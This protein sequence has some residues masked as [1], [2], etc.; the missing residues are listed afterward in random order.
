MKSPKLLTLIA[1]NYRF[2]VLAYSERAECR[3][4][5]GE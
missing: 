5:S 1:V 3:I 2:V 4:Q